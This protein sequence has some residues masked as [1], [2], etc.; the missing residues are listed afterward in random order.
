MIK[1]IYVEHE[2]RIGEN[3][4]KFINGFGEK[5]KIDVETMSEQDENLLESKNIDLY[6]L[7]YSEVSEEIIKKIRKN[8]PQSLIYGISGGGYST[9]GE[10]DRD[11]FDVFCYKHTILNHLEKFLSSIKETTVKK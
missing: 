9:L 7:H 5:E 10:K 2:G 1:R 6:V 11:I 3:L 4:I 8:N